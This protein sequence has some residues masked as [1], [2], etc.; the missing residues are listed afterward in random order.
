MSAPWTPAPVSPVPTI[1]SEADLERLLA[2]EP[3]RPVLIFKHSTTCPIS[4]AAYRRFQDAVAAGD[5]VG[6]QPILVR[7]IEERP[8]SQAIAKRWA[9][10]HASP[11][12]LLVRGPHVVW[13]ASHERITREA[14]AMAARSVAPPA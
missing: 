4:A 13:Q 6:V 14:L 10:P 3:S 1:K 12:A 8:L 11:Q 9:V 5:L 7:V 2:E